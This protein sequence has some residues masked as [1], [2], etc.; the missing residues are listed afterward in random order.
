MFIRRSQI[1]VLLMLRSALYANQ[2][3][4]TI[5]TYIFV[6]MNFNNTKFV[7]KEIKI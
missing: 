5:I 4:L 6:L 7:F 3:N 1:D 2:L